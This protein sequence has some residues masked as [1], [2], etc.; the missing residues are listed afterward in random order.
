MAYGCRLFAFK[1]AKVLM[2]I[3]RAPALLAIYAQTNWQIAKAAHQLQVARP[4][5]IIIFSLF[6]SIK[7]ANA[8]LFALTAITANL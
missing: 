5:Q 7:P 1:N 6:R 3:I 2:L 4:V 8:S